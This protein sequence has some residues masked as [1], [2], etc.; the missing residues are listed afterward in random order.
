MKDTRVEPP[1]SHREVVVLRNVWAEQ[2]ETPILEDVSLTVE[3]GDFLG[4]IGPNGGG[5]STLLKVIL[6]LVKPVRGDVRVWGRP[7]EDSAHLIGYVPQHS[8]FDPDFPITVQDVVLM[9]RL[10]RPRLLRG[11]GQ[12]EC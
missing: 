12:R 11:N 3:K 4:V 6:G 5:K 2:G 8:L 1:E 7:P 10:S 9:G